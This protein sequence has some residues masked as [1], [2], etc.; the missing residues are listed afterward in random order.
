MAALTVSGLP[1]DR[2]LFAGF[3]PVKAG[4][5]RRFL[6]DLAQVPATLVLFEAPSRTAAS[7]AACAEVLGEREAALCRELTKRFEE[8]RRGTL[9]QL[10]ASA[11]AEAP[12]GE[13]VLVIDRGRQPPDS[14]DVEMRLREA[15]R[16]MSVKDAAGA[17]AEALSLPKRH[18]YQTAL[19]L[20]G[21]LG[22]NS[23]DWSRKSETKAGRE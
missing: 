13:V 23:G 7:L 9:A 1:T 3:P 17:V 5:R 12:R 21:A 11:G 6:A 22:E 4:E 15:L 8:V 19:K 18:V 2:F 10:A 14:A 20:A 16:T